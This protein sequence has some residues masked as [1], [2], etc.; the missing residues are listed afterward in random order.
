VIPSPLR[1]LARWIQACSQQNQL[2]HMEAFSQQPCRSLHQGPSSSR[3]DQIKVPH[4]DVMSIC[5]CAGPALVLPVCCIR[6][7]LLSL[8]T[9]H[10]GRFCGFAGTT[11]PRHRLR[12]DTAN[13]TEQNRHNHSSTY[14]H[15]HYLHF[16]KQSK[17]GHPFPP[18]SRGSLEAMSRLQIQNMSRTSF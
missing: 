3:S 7:G 10:V 11:S 9:A 16:T 12:A 4:L 6:S 2:L 8:Q 18:L 13:R 14:P 15:I 5:R 1:S 17:A